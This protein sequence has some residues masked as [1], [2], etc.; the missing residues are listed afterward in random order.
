MGAL[1]LRS[2]NRDVDLRSVD[3]SQEFTGGLAGPRSRADKSLHNSAVT[4]ESAKAS[5]I[6]A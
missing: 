1:C 3:G 4:L 6:E 2:K 5:L